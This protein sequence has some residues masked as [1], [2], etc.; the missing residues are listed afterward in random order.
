[1]IKE[2]IYELCQHHFEGND[3]LY[4]KCPECGSGSVQFTEPTM[5]KENP[6][7]VNPNIPHGYIIDRS[8]LLY[9]TECPHAID[10]YFYGH[11]KP[12]CEN[13]V[14][15]VDCLISISVD[16][17]AVHLKLDKILNLLEPKDLL[18]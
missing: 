4:E 2:C 17:S 15:S 11:Y 13:K 12:S 16:V 7:I 5:Y 14:F 8:S 18:N 10:C 1:M 6:E 3:E 9:A